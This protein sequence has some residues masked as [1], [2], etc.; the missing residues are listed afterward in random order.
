MV[1]K[2]VKKFAPAGQST[3]MIIGADGSSD[4]D[5][6]M[7]SEALYSG[8]DLKRVYYSAFSPIPDSSAALPLIRPPLMPVW[9]PVAGKVINEVLMPH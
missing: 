2:T 3:Q 6:L 1:T 8:Y 5:I 4:T 7:R 9:T